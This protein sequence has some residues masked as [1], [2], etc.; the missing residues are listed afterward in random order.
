MTSRRTKRE[1]EIDEEEE[2]E[3]SI[4]TWF[5]SLMLWVLPKDFLFPF[6]P[7]LKAAVTHLVTLLLA[8][9]LLASS[10]IAVLHRSA[11]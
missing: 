9:H 3:A 7:E 4:L 2:E 6:S 11:S 5:M 8:S 1:E 10:R